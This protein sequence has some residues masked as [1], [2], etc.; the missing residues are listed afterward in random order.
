MRLILIDG[1][2]LKNKKFKEVMQSYEFRKNAITNFLTILNSSL[3]YSVPQ[4][5]DVAGPT[6]SDPDIDALSVSEETLVCR[7][8]FK[9]LR[10]CPS[11]VVS[12]P[13]ICDQNLCKKKERV[14]N[15]RRAS[16][17]V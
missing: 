6:L 9:D 2:L 12:S 16:L 15:N 1:D 8:F 3:S 7:P 14:Y 13:L 11:I 4:L 17:T 5:L 10:G